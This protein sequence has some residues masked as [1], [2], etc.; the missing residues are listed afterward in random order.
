MTID[1]MQLINILYIFN[2]CKSLK[3]CAHCTEVLHAVL[4]QN[5]HPGGKSDGVRYGLD[6]LYILNF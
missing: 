2:L 1:S 4:K 3:A 6:V 5:K